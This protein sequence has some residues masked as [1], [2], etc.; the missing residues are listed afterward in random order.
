MASSIMMQGGELGEIS[1]SRCLES[2][3]PFRIPRYYYGDISNETTN[4][5]II[6]ERIPFGQKEGANQIDPPYEKGRDWELKGTHEE[7]LGE[8]GASINL[9]LGPSGN[10]WNPENK[11][12]TT[13][14]PYGAF[15]TGRCQP[16]EEYYELL[17]R[18]GAK[19]AGM[20]KAGKLAPHAALDKV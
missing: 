10:F 11:T 3:L 20:A 2:R 14:P 6:T 8:F 4:F 15:T 19:M 18:T 12:A 16:P 9:S 7:L 13:G 17:V 5:I 1:A